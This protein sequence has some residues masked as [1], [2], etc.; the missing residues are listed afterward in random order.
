MNGR[1]TVVTGRR[2]YDDPKMLLPDAEILRHIHARIIT[3]WRSV[4][5]CF[6]SVD[7]PQLVL[8]KLITELESV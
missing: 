1:L 5:P 3:S 8:P 7:A 4:Q 2:A 6:T